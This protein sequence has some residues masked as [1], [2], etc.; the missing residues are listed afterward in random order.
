VRCDL[1]DYM[2]NVFGPFRGENPY[3]YAGIPLDNVGVE[4]GLAALRSGII[5]PA[6]FVDLN[7]K[8][9]G[10]D[11][12]YDP[13][14]ARFTAQEP[15]LA[16]DYRSGAVN[17]ANNLPSV[18]IIDLRGPDPGAFHDAYR[19]WTI[20]ARLEAVEHHFPKN[21]VIWFGETPLIGDPQYTTEGLLA[22]DRWLSAVAADHRSI[23]LAA[24]I[25][26]DRPSDVHD[27]CS[28]VPGVDQVSLPGAGPVCQLPLAQTRFATP[29]MVA[30]ES[31]ATDVE[32]CRLVPLSQSSFYPVTFTDAEWDA[33]ERLF[34]GGV[35]DWSR[36]GVDQ[37]R[38]I[39][40]LT[41]QSD[42]AGRRVIY[43]GQ[44]LGRA[45]AWSGEGWA[46]QSFASWLSPR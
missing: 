32:K 10:Y 41:Y 14:R 2:I 11:N 18:A 37:R 9:G 3:G 12:N 46:S 24:K 21:D 45:P 25:A 44:P 15:A 42:P 30:G 7:E 36:R 43:G 23:P 35:C 39:P 19:S 4:Y 31:I 28:D 38:T 22:M 29:R 6:Q 33:L 8:I 34:V 20:R 1:E 26:A 27:Q 17:E 13:T 40:W 16:N 5:T